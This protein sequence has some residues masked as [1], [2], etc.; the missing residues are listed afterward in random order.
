MKLLTL[1]GPTC[2]GKSQM[3]VEIA[4]VF[5]KEKVVI[6]NCD[7]RQI[8]QELNIGTAKVDGKWQ[9]LEKWNL[10]K[11]KKEKVG[12]GNEKGNNLDNLTKNSQKEFNLN[13]KKTQKENQ[14]SERF[15]NLWENEP[16][17]VDFLDCSDFLKLILESEKAFFWQEVPHFLIDFVP[18]EANYN[19]VDF[20]QDWIFLINFLE[21]NS[22]DLVILTGGTGLWARAIN[23][24][25]DFGIIKPEFLENWQKLKSDLEK[26]SLDMLQKKYLEILLDI[27]NKNL[28]TQIPKIKTARINIEINRNIEINT[29]IENFLEINSQNFAETLKTDKFTK[30]TKRTHI[31]TQENVKKNPRKNSKIEIKSE[32]LVQNLP[33]NLPQNLIFPKKISGKVENYLV[34]LLKNKENE[35]FKIQNLSN[36]TLNYNLEN[37]Q[38]MESK[39]L[40]ESDFQNP[41]RL[42]NWL[43]REKSQNWTKKLVYPKFEKSVIFGIKTGENLKLK[44]T[45]GIQKRIEKG[46]ESE[47]ENLLKLG[48]E[49]LWNFGLEYRQTL[50]FWEEKMNKKTWQNNLIQQNYQ[51]ARRQKIWL[52]KQNLIWIN[53]LE[54]LLWEIQKINF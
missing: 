21:K 40:N 13:K 48:R 24:K 6:V 20:V 37:I 10:G 7:S 28:E 2:S 17:E 16:K 3:T 36:H 23:Q 8:Y 49:K 5:N 51:Y 42:I 22:V 12:K 41:V 4:K 19:L 53:D 39:M 9:N 43:L 50:L 47:V 52:Q 45:K 31:E 15:G 14:N 29:E 25:Y 46:L 26:E 38:K 27:W 11:I 32:N 1:L 54:E 30:L 35:P 44:I 33:Q 18:P 34:E